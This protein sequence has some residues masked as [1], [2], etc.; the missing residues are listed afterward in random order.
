[1]EEDVT[2]KAAILLGAALLAFW[3]MGSIWQPGDGGPT[4][5]G[6]CV[7]DPNGR[8]VCQP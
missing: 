2:M 6:G 4:T 7:I 8:P 3:L 1:M 5:Q